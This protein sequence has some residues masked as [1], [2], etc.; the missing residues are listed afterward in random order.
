VARRL[1]DL[2]IEPRAGT[3]DALRG[4]LVSDIAKWKAV[5]GRAKIPLQ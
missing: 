1:Q 2:G 5:I 4:Q 3:P